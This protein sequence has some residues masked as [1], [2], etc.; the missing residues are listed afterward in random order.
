VGD[1]TQEVS[2]LIEQLRRGSLSEMLMALV[3]LGEIGHDAKP[4]VPHI[5]DV[6]AS[7][8]HWFVHVFAV[9]ALTAMGAVGFNALIACQ[10]HADADVRLFAAIGVYAFDQDPAAHEVL[11]NA[12]RNRVRWCLHAAC[13]LAQHSKSFDAYVGILKDHLKSDDNNGRSMAI[14]ALA[15]SGYRGPDILPLV[16]AALDDAD[17]SIQ[18]AAVKIL[19][20]MGSLATQALPKLRQLAASGE[21]P[22]SDAAQKVAEALEHG[23]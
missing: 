11:V 8:E 17:W 10:R 15:A 20:S 16:I 5:M 7:P 2:R 21:S 6:L 1:K 14:L 18:Y 3:K 19:G 4:A 22:V 9:R 13:A 12:C 23:L